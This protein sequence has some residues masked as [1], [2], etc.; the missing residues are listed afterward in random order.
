MPAGPTFHGTV[1]NTLDSSPKALTAGFL[2][3][4]FPTG[5]LISGLPMGT[6]TPGQPPSVSSC[7]KGGCALPRQPLPVFVRCFFRPSRV[8]RSRRLPLALSGLPCSASG[9]PR[10]NILINVPRGPMSL[11]NCKKI[12]RYC[13]RLASQQGSW[14]FY[15]RT[16]GLILSKLTQGRTIFSQGKLLEDASVWS[17]VY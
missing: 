8:S 11:Q 4:R 14:D 7:R 16:P 3:P 15:I 6:D 1:L 2:Q 5:E 17:S 9:W 12:Q 10:S 13:N